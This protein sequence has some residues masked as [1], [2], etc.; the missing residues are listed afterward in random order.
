M[1]LFEFEALY[2]SQY[3]NSK[4]TPPIQ[5]ITIESQHESTTHCMVCDSPSQPTY[6]TLIRSGNR[7]IVGAKIPAYEC[8]NCGVVVEDIP[9][10]IEFLTKTSQSLKAVGNIREA[11]RVRQELKGIQLPSEIKITPSQ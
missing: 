1:A 7:L 4:N 11:A 10:A 9:G 8:N 2:R 5:V 3:P 6:T